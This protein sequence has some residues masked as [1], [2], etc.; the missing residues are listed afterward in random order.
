[1][2]VSL[3]VCFVLLLSYVLSD[4]ITTREG[5]GKPFGNRKPIQYIEEIDNFPDPKT[6]N[7]NYIIPY[8]PVK[9]K[10]V[11]KISPAFT[12]WTDDYFISL[13]EPSD[14]VVSV[15]TRKKEDRTQA[16]KEMPF[17]E[18][19]KSY[20]TSGIYMVNPVP[21]FIGGDLVLP[22]PLQCRDIIDKGLVE[23]IMWFSSGGTKSVVHTDSVDNINCLYRGQKSFV[24][25]DPTKYG[26]KV[27]ID[28]PEGAYSAV[29]VDSVDYTKYP[30]LS[31]VEFYHTNL[32][33]GDCL[34]I[35]YKWIH[36][37]RSYDSNL[38][39]NIWWDHFKN[40]DVNWNDCN[41]KC[42]PKLTFTKIKFHGFD[43]QM[44]NIQQIKD[45][46]Q[47]ILKFPKEMDANKF[48]KAILGNDVPYLKETGR[49]ED[50]KSVILELFTIMDLDKDT[51]LSI[52]EVKLAPDEV[53]TE[54][55]ELM[56]ELG[57]ILDGDMPETDD[58]NQHDEL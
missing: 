16:V 2:F 19:V 52:D 50:A 34:Y 33:A 11:A 8:K 15:E 26:D 7:E 32:S 43:G 56:I 30:G 6:F 27:D 23:N 12:K 47:D 9:M 25:V 38:A 46:F 58:E 35:P 3:S 1:M 51:I 10:N 18:F 22:C 45:H 28:H 54:G 29:D 53:W 49:Y 44:D 39:V 42:D 55:R 41:A 21:P 17:V 5:H 4:D 36:Q 14:H 57:H 48:L 24:I 20:N 13:K 37:V 31:E 40:N